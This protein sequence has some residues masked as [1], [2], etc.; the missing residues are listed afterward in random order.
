MW[1]RCRPVVQ[2]LL[3]PVVAELNDL[4]RLRSLQLLVLSEVDLRACAHNV[5]DLFLPAHVD[6]SLFPFDRQPPLLL[7]GVHFALVV[8]LVDVLDPN[9]A[10]TPG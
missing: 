2:L 8:G 1:P 6:L 3:P 7:V 5:E 9:Y 4:L 10:V